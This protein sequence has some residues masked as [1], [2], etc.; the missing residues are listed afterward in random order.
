MIK[1]DLKVKCDKYLRMEGVFDIIEGMKR[2]NSS[3]NHVC[4]FGIIF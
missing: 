4:Y 1:I 3:V 2:Y